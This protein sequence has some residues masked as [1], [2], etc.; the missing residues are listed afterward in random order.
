MEIYL[1]RHGAYLPEDQDPDKGL[2]PRGKEQVAAAARRLKELG[3]HPE[4]VVASP[5][6]RAVESAR[7]AAR[8]LGLDP[9]E[10]RTTEALK[11]KAPAEEAVEY[12]AGLGSR[13]VLAAGHLPSLGRV[14]SRLLTGDEEAVGLQL[15]SGA[16]A[17]LVM[18]DPPAGKAKLVC[19]LPPGA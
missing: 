15:G 1:L 18:D 3:V 5:K 10:V 7:E 4:A 16:V 19:L 6:K 2:S 8:Q 11:A 9:A 14:A 17:G 12:L 13:R